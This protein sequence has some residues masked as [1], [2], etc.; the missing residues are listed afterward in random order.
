[1]KASD[2]EYGLITSVQL[3]P[4][5]GRDFGI[6]APTGV[7]AGLRFEAA[8]FEASAVFNGVT[9][10]VSGATSA[11]KTSLHLIGTRNLPRICWT[12]AR[13]PKF[14]MTKN[15]TIQVH[16]FPKSVGWPEALEIVVDDMVVDDVRRK[17]RRLLSLEEVL[18]WLSDRLVLNDGGLT[19]RVLLSGG[20]SI[21]ASASAFRL[22]GHGYA[23]DVKADAEDRLRITR[24]VEAKRPRRVDERRPIVLVE[25]A[26]R[27]VDAT[28][29]GQFRGTAKSLLDELV[30]T[31]TS[32]LGLWKEYNAME[33]DSTKRRARLLGWLY[34]STR[35]LL[36]DGRWRFTLILDDHV[37]A[38]IDRLIEAEDA[39]LEAATRLPA[40]LESPD[41]SESQPEQK[42]QGR[43]FS[44]TF[45]CVDG[46]R[47]TIDVL[48]PNELDDIQ[49]PAKGVLFLSLTGDRK[50]LERREL[51]QSRIAS[52]TCPMPQLGLLIEGQPIPERRARRVDPADAK[53][54]GLIREAMGG[55]PTPRQLEALRV[56]LNTPDLCLIQGPPGTGKTRVIAALQA[57]LA[58]L[59]DSRTNVAGRI[60]L[61]SYQHDAVENAASRTSVFGLPAMKIGKRRNQAE[62]FDGF[63]RWRQDQI[64]AVRSDLAG[65]TDTPIGVILKRV[66]GIAAGYL[67]AA[68][69]NEQVSTMVRA[70]YEL[71]GE[72][73]P[74]A[75]KDRLLACRQRVERAATDLPTLAG[76]E[77]DQALQSVRRIR[78]EP[79]S[80]SDDGPHNSY[81]ALI[82]LQAIGG[83]EQNDV[84]LLARAADWNTDDPLDFLPALLRLKGALVDRLAPPN[85]MASLPQIDAEVEQLLSEVVDALFV[86]VRSSSAG[87]PDVLW[88]YLDALEN[89]IY[90]VRAAVKSYTV[91]LAATC[92]QA[93]GKQMSDMKLAGVSLRQLNELDRRMVFNDIIID[94]AARANPLDLFVP[95]ALAERRIVLVGD[96]RQLPHI[97]EPDV[98]REIER[99][100]R[101]ETRELLKKSLFE[102]LFTDL[103]SREDRD[104]FKRTITL[105]KQFRM[106][107]TLGKFVSATFY[108]PYGEEFESIKN[109]G[110]FEHDLDSYAGCVAAWVNIPAADG[111]ETSGRSKRR[112][113]EAK[114]IAEEVFRLA[115]RRPDLSFGVITF[116]AAQRDE[117]MGALAVHG[118]TEASETGGFEIREAWRETSGTRKERLRVGTVDAFQGKEFDVVLLSV[119]RS[120]D[121]DPKDQ[122]SL[123]RKYGH[124][125]L[126]N[127]LCVA[128][129]RQHRLLIAVGDA[130]MVV[131]EAAANA[132]P[133]LTKFY[134]L[135][136]GPNGIRL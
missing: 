58:E 37:N 129:S 49:P 78:T 115:S 90:G 2:L 82:R 100:V 93:A 113:V 108:E 126:E 103:R 134:N 87:E 45:T 83:L 110:Q 11:D 107:P 10:G 101:E 51:A 84:D 95:M 60:L 22:H 40:E 70:I 132:V 98:E 46:S 67:F 105:N 33:W 1:V 54:R 32:Y 3:V 56:A 23:I 86:C 12:L 76:D 52:A 128:M 79:E 55:E 125:M 6:Q 119:T 50:R 20:T 99:S 94:E 15:T 102:R 65:A 117:L 42:P 91:V 109:T 34:Y 118:I 59:D 127:R 21:D 48:P 106:H 85:E 68:M 92:Q 38:S 136:G 44:G 61:T 81:K 24:V 121:I 18:Q 89:D 14:G 16:E 4:A 69:P 57:I 130:A 8:T 41:E 9:Y 96:H 63:H 25:S 35:T 75:L 17:R 133:G 116:Y 77:R 66:Q 131:G 88:E 72:H 13:F 62:E 111:P 36:P 104:G 123:R 124:L 7:E 47:R 27:F 43:A 80:F 26:V 28:V 135:C 112:R 71:A 53:Y 120:N 30:R 73:L 97:L 29:A 39:Q 5:T 31:S 64:E 74:T 114:R 122:R 19:S